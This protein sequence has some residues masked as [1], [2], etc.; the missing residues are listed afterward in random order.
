MKKTLLIFVGFLLYI[1]ACWLVNFDEQFIILNSSGQDYINHFHLYYNEYLFLNG[2]GVSSTEVIAI[3]WDRLYIS[4][5][6]I[7]VF[8]SLLLEFRSKKRK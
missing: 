2:K 7:W 4:V 5:V 8:T 6:F 3:K 1:A